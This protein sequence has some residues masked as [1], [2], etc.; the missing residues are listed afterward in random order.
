MAFPTDH[1]IIN[2]LLHITQL[3]LM[4]SRN[5]QEVIPF[6]HYNHK[7]ISQKANIPALFLWHKQSQHLVTLPNIVCGPT[8]G[9]QVPSPLQEMQCKSSELE[10]GN[11]TE[12]VSK[13]TTPRCYPIPVDTKHGTHQHPQTEC[14][15]VQ[16]RCGTHPVNME[17]M[18]WLYKWLGER[19]AQWQKWTFSNIKCNNQWYWW[20]GACRQTLEL[21]FNLPCSSVCDTVHKCTSYCKMCWTTIWPTEAQQNDH[22]TDQPP[23]LQSWK[24]SLLVTHC[25]LQWDVGGPLHSRDKDESMVWKHFTSPAKENCEQKEGDGNSCLRHSEDGSWWFHTAWCDDE[26][27]C[28]SGVIT[29]H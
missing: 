26:Y 21:A 20:H 5:T 16:C 11:P 24:Q 2:L 22:L 8:A 15:H 25:H 12:S 19:H 13:G 17:M 4:K 18:P 6:S 23:T 14:G 1:H 9:Q 3:M 29:M 28:L 7:R 10:N 27:S